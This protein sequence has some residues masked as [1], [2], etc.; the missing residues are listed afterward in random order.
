MVRIFGLLLRD[1]GYDVLSFSNPE[2]AL[3]A[4]KEQSDHIDLVITDMTMPDM[5]GDKLTREI[6]RIKP[7][8]PVILCSGYSDLFTKDEAQDIGISAYSMK[9][10]VRKDIALTIRELLDNRI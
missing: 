6:T 3:A 1:L 5:N 4:F 10:V 2:E 7:G 9:P 8:V